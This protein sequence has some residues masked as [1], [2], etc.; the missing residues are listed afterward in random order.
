MMTWGNQ[1]ETALEAIVV[2]RRSVPIDR[3][4]YQGM[5]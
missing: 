2:P 1:M 5:A 4:V 3:R